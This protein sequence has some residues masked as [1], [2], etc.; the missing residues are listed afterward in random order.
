MQSSTP[1]PLHILKVV[2]RLFKY[3]YITLISLESI[4]IIAN[5]SSEILTLPKLSKTKM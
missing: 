4:L 2:Y 3:L 5:R 1:H